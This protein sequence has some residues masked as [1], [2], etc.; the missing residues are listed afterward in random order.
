MGDDWWLSDWLIRAAFRVAARRLPLTT[1]VIV[2]VLWGHPDVKA[3]VGAAPC[4]VGT[5]Q[6]GV[7]GHLAREQGHAAG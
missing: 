4:E 2:G 5:C 7:L 6:T 3:K 1:S